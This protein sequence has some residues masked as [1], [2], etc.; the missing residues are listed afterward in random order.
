[1]EMIL[2][3]EKKQRAVTFR[4]SFIAFKRTF[5]ISEKDGWILELFIKNIMTLKCMIKSYKNCF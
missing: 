2:E 5:S 4:V 1:M 3:G